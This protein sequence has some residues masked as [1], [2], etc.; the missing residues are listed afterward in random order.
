MMESSC[1][2]AWKVP[3]AVENHLTFGRHHFRSL[4]LFP[5]HG[6]PFLEI[7]GSKERRVN[8]RMVNIWILIP[9]PSAVAFLFISKQRQRRERESI[10]SYQRLIQE[11]FVFC[12]LINRW[13]TWRASWRPWPAVDQRKRKAGLQVLP[14]D[15]LPNHELLLLSYQ[16]F[17]LSSLNHSQHKIKRKMKDQWF[18]EDWCCK[19]LER[20]R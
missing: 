11:F 3:S 7:C 13:E 18:R 9:V 5:S 16:I 6:S 2:L 4:S 20:R 15:A 8:Q 14:S 10:H 12:C 1:L 17:F 19:D